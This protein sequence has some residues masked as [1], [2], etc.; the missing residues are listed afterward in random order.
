MATPVY[1]IDAL[2]WAKKEVT[3]NT[4]QTLV[5]GDGFT[6]TDLS[7]EPSKAWTK[8]A[9]HTGSASLQTEIAGVEGGSW[10]ATCYVKPS[11]TAGTAPEGGLAVLLEAALGQATNVAVTSEKYHLSGA[12]PPTLQIA[13]SAGV[14]LFE[15]IT[16]AW[17]ESIEVALSGNEPPTFSISG[18]F[19]QYGFV[20]DGLAA[21]T[22][23]GTLITLEDATV[24]DSGKIAAGVQVLFSGDVTPRVV[25]SVDYANAQFT[26]AIAT[27]ATGTP[28]ITPSIP[29]HSY[30][31][32]ILGGV[33]NALTI[34]A[35]AM[36]VVSAKFSV[37]TGYHGLDR[38]ATSNR[39]TRIA[40][41]AREVTGEL[42]FYY[43]DEN[44]GVMGSAHYNKTRAIT[45]T[46]GSVAGSQLEVSVPA[47]RID[48]T[49]VELPEADEATMSGGFVCRKS[50]TAEDE[51]AL[52]FK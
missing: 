2:G 37:S 15:Q 48:V 30:S 43:L 7:F 10:S 50:A 19:A 3:F 18:G 11:G 23:V 12:N 6:F 38:E 49:K 16:G 35:L 8:S 1:G 42:E 32:S 46:M 39:A 44:A 5:A 20:Y 13:K 26:T 40:R 45:L 24:F 34:D 27:T 4:A 29:S 9:E 41:G 28:T 47:A 52:T 36:G 22:I 25:A 51:I 31:G 14:G 33:D 21:K 17:V